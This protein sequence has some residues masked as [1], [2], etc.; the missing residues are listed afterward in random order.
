MIQN[1]SDREHSQPRKPR[2]TW[3]EDLHPS[4]SRIA[5]TTAGSR[6]SHACT[7]TSRT[8][9]V[10]Y[11]DGL[12]YSSKKGFF[13]PQNTYLFQQL[14]ALFRDLLDVGVPDGI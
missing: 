6:A 3:V 11:P 8:V 2:A 1:E 9:S 7:R 10:F 13:E 4:T 12:V 5:T 14:E